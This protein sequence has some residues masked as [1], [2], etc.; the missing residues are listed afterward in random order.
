MEIN[1]F[2]SKIRHQEKPKK[3]LF[4]AF[5]ITKELVKTA[6]WTIDE[7]E[8]KVLSLGDS[9]SWQNEEDLLTN[10]D[11]SLS[12][13]LS[14]LPESEASEPNKVIFGLPPDWV[15]DDKI[16]TEKAALLKNIV[17]KLELSP[18]GFVVIPEAIIH[19]LKTSE[20]LPPTAILLGLEKQEVTVTLVSLGKIIGSHVVVRSGNL[21]ADLAEGLSRLDSVGPFPSR[22][23]LYDGP[24][25]VDQARQELLNYSFGEANIN[26]LHLPKVETLPLESDI[27]AVALAGGQ[28]FAKNAGFAGA[29]MIPVEQTAPEPI[30]EEETLSSAETPEEG[31]P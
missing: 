20:G 10:L 9:K 6:I 21:G 14:V 13:A 29:P 26:F 18:L 28:E 17:E 22:I 23:L 12:Q 27:Q 5:Q 30:I 8:I 4:F 25:L 7:G 16:V 11:A 24:L 3:E 19:Y 31:E 1:T 15:A 2:L